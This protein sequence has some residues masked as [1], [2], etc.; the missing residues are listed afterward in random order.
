MG[1]RKEPLEK[2]RY[3]TGHYKPK[4]LV[5]KGVQK[6]KK[7]REET[8]HKK[9]HKVHWGKGKTLLGKGIISKKRISKN[10]LVFRKPEGKVVG[11]DQERTK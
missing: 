3:S 5:P 10:G 8:M 2:G 9:S 7:I 11:P 4:E 1:E 6:K